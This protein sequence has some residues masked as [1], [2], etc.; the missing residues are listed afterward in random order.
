MRIVS[1]IIL[2]IHGVWGFLPSGIYCCCNPKASL[3]V[4]TTTLFHGRR[5]DF[6]WERRDQQDR[7]S[8]LSTSERAKRAMLAEAVEDNILSKELE[9]EEI[10][11]EQGLLP[12]DPELLKQCQDLAREIRVAQQQYDAL[13]GGEPSTLLR[14]L[15]GLQMDIE[16]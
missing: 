15:E 11:G 9:L 14:T 7:I 8:K 1:F 6:S 12:Q 10:L 3:L 4:A 5:D 2:L 16:S 13:V